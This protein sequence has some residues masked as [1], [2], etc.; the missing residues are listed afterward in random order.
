MHDVAYNVTTNSLKVSVGV[1]VCVC[2]CVCILDQQVYVCRFFEAAQWPTR[3]TTFSAWKGPTA[4]KNI[5]TD[6]HIDA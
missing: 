5:H 2:V 3:G 6:I 1:C 4:G